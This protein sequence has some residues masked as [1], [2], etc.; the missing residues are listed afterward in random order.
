[1]NIRLITHLLEVRARNRLRAIMRGSRVLR[2]SVD[3][4]LVAGI[5]DALK[6]HKFGLGPKNT[7]VWFF[8]AA[9]S[10]AELAVRQYLLSRL[11]GQRLTEALL[12]AY[13]QRSGGGKVATALPLEWRLILNEHGIPV[14]HF[15]SALAWGAYVGGQ[16]LFGLALFVRRLLTGIVRLVRPAN[17]Q[18]GNFVYFDSLIPGALPQESEDKNS[19][20]I[21][22]WYM[23]HTLGEKKFDYFCHGIKG[24]RSMALGNTLVVGVEGPVFTL[25]RFSSLI[26]FLIWGIITVILVIADILRGRWIYALMFREAI[27]TA[28]VRLEQPKRL[29][30]EY[31]FHNSNFV[32]RPLWTY[33]AEKQGSEILMYF[34]STNCEPFKRK[35]GYKNSSNE[36]YEVMSWS[37][38]LVWD[39]YQANFIRRSVGPFAKVEVVGPIWFTSSPEEL[40]PLP[41]ATIALFDVQPVRDSFYQRHAIEFDYY[42]PVNSIAFIAD[43]YNA[44]KV[45]RSSIVLKRKRKIGSL[46]HPVYESFVDRITE[47]PGFINISPEV[48]ASRLIEKCIAVISMPFTS[49]ALIGKAL[50]KPSAYYDPRGMIQKDDRGAHGIEILSGPDELSSWLSKALNLSQ[51]MLKEG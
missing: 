2:N 16:F 20:D 17:N 4:D 45:C 34:Y 49:T 15:R 31:L 26:R 10:H 22:T 21:M 43:I 41:L 12:V 29:A 42:T 50:G 9:I 7:S 1:M 36:Y 51:P 38:Y 32:Y 3:P 46:I 40:P 24:V 6:N 37:R 14:A 30:R 19:Y 18:L 35:F 11:G 28:Q 8:G 47:A 13:G 25:D 23:K 27:K 48:S 44:A 33:Q 39:T 5:K